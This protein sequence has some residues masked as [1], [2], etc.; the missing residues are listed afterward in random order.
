MQRGVRLADLPVAEFQAAH[1]S[2]DES[3]YG[4]LGVERAIEAFVSYGSTAP[5]Q[6]DRQVERWKQRLG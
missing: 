2:L 1:A 3:V 6:V 5:S 4:V